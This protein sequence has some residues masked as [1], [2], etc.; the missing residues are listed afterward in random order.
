MPE[1]I[2]NPVTMKLILG[3]LIVKTYLGPGRLSKEADSILF[4]K[5]MAALGMHILLL[6]PTMTACTAKMDQ[7]FE[8]F[9]LACSKSA[10][11]VALRK[12]QQRMMVWVENTNQVVSLLDGSDDNDKVDPVIDDGLGKHRERN[13]CHVSISNKDL[14]NLVNGWPN[15]RVELQLFDCHLNPEWIIV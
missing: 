10:L 15:D 3:P 1:P 11:H 9:K 7:L 2:C 12:I 8:K 4:C 14:G 5:Q 13:I 6:L